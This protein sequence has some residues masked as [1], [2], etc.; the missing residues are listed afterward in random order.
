M[1]ADQG[2]PVREVTAARL[3]YPS[4]GTMES[5]TQERKRVAL[6]MQRRIQS[7]RLFVA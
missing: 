5:T 4:T 6:D 1:L 7:H 3:P 2:V